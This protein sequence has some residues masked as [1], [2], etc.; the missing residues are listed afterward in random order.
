ML[1]YSDK[2]QFRFT[3]SILD[4]F[5]EDIT[6]IERNNAENEPICKHTVLKFGGNKLFIIY[7]FYI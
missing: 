3:V 6:Y 5:P 1:K 2:I 4:L 7:I